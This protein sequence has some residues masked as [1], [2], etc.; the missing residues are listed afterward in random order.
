M[1][2]KNKAKGFTLVELVVVVVIIGILAA[3]AAPRFL[4]KTDAAKAQVTLQ[5]ASAMRSAIEI[6]RADTGSYPTS[7]TALDTALEAYIRGGVPSV[8]FKTLSGAKVHVITGTDPTSIP[9]GVA[10]GS[11]WIYNSSTGSVW[12]NDTDLFDGKYDG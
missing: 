3:V 12:V 1:S 5:K 6:L 10:S 9:T 8:D 4:N 7:D 11:V 2:A